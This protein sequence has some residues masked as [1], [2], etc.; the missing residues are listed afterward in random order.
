MV[1]SK[2]QK[3]ASNI[4]D[5]L[6][7]IYQQKGSSKKLKLN[8]DRSY[9]LFNPEGS[10]HYEVEQCLFSS[11]GKWS[12]VSND[13]VEITSEN[14]YSR[15]KGFEY[16][17]KKENKLS[18][19]S[20]YIEIRLPDAFIN[21]KG[22]EA[23]NFAITFNNN[24]GKSISTNKSIVGLSKSKYLWDRKIN[25]NFL[26]INLNANISGMAIY[27]SR[28]T[29]DIFGDYVDTEKYN[30]LTITLPNFDLCF[31]EFEPYNQEL[32]FIKGKNQLIWNGKIWE[33]RRKDQ[34]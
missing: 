6:V 8:S 10:G 20:L 24:N 5:N 18:Q 22:K 33:K 17:L 30:Y 28:I 14:Y 31:F 27:K 11:K 2:A 3:I 26:S 34:K 19:D 21:S 32:I 29:F 25:T 12:T 13:V 4:E 16:E 1:D 15:Q 7:G 23:V 9:I